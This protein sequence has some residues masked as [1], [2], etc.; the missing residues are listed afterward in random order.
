[1]FRPKYSISDQ[2]LSQL[3]EISEIKALVSKSKLLPEREIFLK[4]AAVVR[5]AHTSTSIE[6]NALK[7]FQ[8]AQLAEG[9]RVNASEDQVREVKNYLSALKVVDKLSSAK[10]TFNTK[11]VLTI[12]R[13]VI[14][15]LVEKEKTGSFRKGSVFVVN[16]LP[17]KKE[18]VAYTPPPA[19]KVPVLIQNLLDWLG[20]HQEVHPIIRAGLFHYQFET[21]HPFTDGNGR[22]GRLLTLL[23][24]YQS[25]WDFKKVL[26][27][28]D[29]YNRDRKAY[30]LALQTG[31]TYRERESVDLTSW[32]DYFVAGF[33]DEARKVKD[34][35]LNLS[36]VGDLTTTRN[37]LDRDELKIV[38]FVVSL[39]RITSSDVVEILSVPKRTAQ[40][41]LKKLEEIKVLVKNGAGP[42]TYYSI[43]RGVEK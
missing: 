29:Y 11:D 2:L 3:S 13:Q 24:L 5:M 34:Q 39:G 4:R 30:Y 41:K 28:E 1:M 19:E 36:V 23:H 9:K 43:P 31:K 37:V 15:G 7:E 18:E 14:D 10:K 32:L 21:I 42:S 38:D 25:G 27:L 22:C 17:S 40:S 6:G 8:V 12:H 33:L 20:K 26:I 35:I 16:V